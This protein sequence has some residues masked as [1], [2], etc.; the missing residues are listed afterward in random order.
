[1]F[2]VYTIVLTPQVMRILPGRVLAFALLPV[3]A[4]AHPELHNGMTT[5]TTP[6]HPQA[7][8]SLPKYYKAPYQAKLIAVPFLEPREGYS[9]NAAKPR[10]LYE[11]DSGYTA[12]SCNNGYCCEAGFTCEVSNGQT[13]CA[14]GGI[15]N[16]AV[17]PISAFPATSGPSYSPIPTSGGTAGVLTSNAAASASSA[18]APGASGNSVMSYDSSTSSGIGI[19][20]IVGIVI[21]GIFILAVA[22]IA[23]CI[24][25]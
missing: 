13:V 3:S 7:S 6:P 12:N 25:L 2:V 8:Q 16:G 4:L 23:A 19:G 9:N 10:L 24:L 20:A 15:T 18:G 14:P 22:I 17:S 1:M 5:V 11:R 21:G